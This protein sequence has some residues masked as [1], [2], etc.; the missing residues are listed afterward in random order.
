MI[1]YAKLMAFV[2][3]YG[4]FLSHKNGIDFTVEFVI[5]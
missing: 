3:T 1:L 2:L 5:T 4:I